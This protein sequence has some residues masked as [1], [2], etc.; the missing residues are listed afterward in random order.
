[1]RR[2]MTMGEFNVTFDFIHFNDFVFASKQLYIFEYMS[3]NKGKS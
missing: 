2:G 1:M 3:R